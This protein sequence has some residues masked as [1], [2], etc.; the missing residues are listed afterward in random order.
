MTT[1]KYTDL[2]DKA[3]FYVM[4]KERHEFIQG[5]I[6][7]DI[8]KC[9]DDNAI[10]S[11]FLSPQGRFIAD[12]FII[13]SGDSFLFEINKKIKNELLN[14]FEIYK[15]RAQIEIKETS[16]YKSLVIYE[17]KNFDNLQLIGQCKKIEEG[18]I[19]RDP[20]N[21]KMGIKGIIKEEKIND[22]VSKYNLSKET[23]SD[24]DFKRIN[25]GI[26]DSIIDLKINKSLLLENNFDKI[27]AIDWNKGCYIGQEITA[28][29][30]YRS[31]LKKTLYKI[32]IL[33]GDVKKDDMIFL[34]DKNIGYITSIN[35]NLGLAMLKISEANIAIKNNNDLLVKNGK[36][37]LSI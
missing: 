4:G 36:I 19:Y 1:G 15:L 17:N 12:F 23:I 16:A 29:M 6:T 37:K 28:R 2:S 11:A 3:F 27:N 30:K 21:N 33:E 7:N 26:P 34:N 32:I 10:Y 20:R 25:N 24:Y 18:F 22:F 9:N 13:S 35:K 8:N 31:L 5:L 14:K